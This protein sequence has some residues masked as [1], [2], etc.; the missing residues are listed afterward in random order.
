[1]TQSTMHKRGMTLA[2]GLLTLL[3]G[4]LAAARTPGPTTLPA[5]LTPE[6]IAQRGPFYLYGD[7][8][9]LTRISGMRMHSYKSLDEVYRAFDGNAG[10]SRFVVVTGTNGSTLTGK[11]ASFRVFRQGCSRSPWLLDGSFT[12]LAGARARVADLEKQGTRRVQL[13]YHYGTR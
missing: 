12:T 2:A 13:V 11:P 4:S 10:R 9:Q 5:N 7:P 3:G 1:M 6:E 8:D